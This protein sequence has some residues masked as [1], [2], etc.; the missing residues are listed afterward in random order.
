MRY[1]DLQ[2]SGGS[3]DAAQIRYYEL[4]GD[5]TY[6][7][8]EVLEAVLYRAA[9]SG[10][11]TREPQAIERVFTRNGWTNGWRD[12]VYDFH[13]YHSTAHE[14]LGCYAGEARLQLGGPYGPVLEFHAGDVLVVPAGVS[15]K[16]TWGSSAF[17]VVGAY[18]DGAD[19][20]MN[21]GGEGE[22]PEADHRI[23][24]TPLPTADPL[25]GPSG[26]LIRRWREAA[27]SAGRRS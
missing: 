21:M 1:D 23:A 25:H 9:F 12:G 6:P 19:Y 27:R 18:A 26:P 14:V 5:G 16:R 3:T 7:N 15:H 22:R 4:L 20:D 2:P 13:H 10:Q 17:R 8:N 24:R 11:G